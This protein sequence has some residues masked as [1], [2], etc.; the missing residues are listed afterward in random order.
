[1]DLEQLLRD[2]E[3]VRGVGYDAD[4]GAAWFDADIASVQAAV[5]KAFPDHVNAL[6]WSLDKSRFVVFSYSDVAPGSFYLWV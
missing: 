5:D 6:S 1:M 4:R 3:G 2:K